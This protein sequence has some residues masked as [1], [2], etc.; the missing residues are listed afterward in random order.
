MIISRM[1]L[2]FPDAPWVTAAKPREGVRRVFAHLAGKPQAE[3][4]PSK[5]LE[6][7]SLSEL[8]YMAMTNEQAAV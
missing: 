2:E 1:R 6:Y 4:A 5:A 7:M 3:A 8:L